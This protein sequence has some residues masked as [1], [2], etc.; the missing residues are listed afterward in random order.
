MALEFPKCFRLQ[1]PVFSFFFV[2]KI[3]AEL[4][5]VPVFLYFMLDAIQRGLT[6]GARSVP[7][8]PTRELP[9]AKVEH[10]N[11]TTTP[12]GRSLQNPIFEVHVTL[13]NF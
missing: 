8:I 12:L 7:R 10:T 3:A 1:N 11:L 6:S 13:L 4:T 2:R 9:A 5:S